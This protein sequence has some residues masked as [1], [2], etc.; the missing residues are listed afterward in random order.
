MFVVDD[1]LN[2]ILESSDVFIVFSR[3]SSLCHV[4]FSHPSRSISNEGCT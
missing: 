1:L 3:V 4:A 2:S